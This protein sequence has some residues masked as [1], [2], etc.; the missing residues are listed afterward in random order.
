MTVAANIVASDVTCTEEQEL[1]LSQDVIKLEELIVIAEA[2]LAYLQYALQNATGT[3]AVF[4][5]T[6]VTTPNPEPEV[7]GKVLSVLEPAPQKPP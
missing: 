3:T 5:T 7:T 2:T 1:E 4:S 6:T